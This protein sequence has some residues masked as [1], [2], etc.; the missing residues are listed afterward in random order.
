[1]KK[2]TGRG[3]RRHGKPEGLYRGCDKDCRMSL[4]KLVKGEKLYVL[5]R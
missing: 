4:A 1:M 2:R 5:G 3:E